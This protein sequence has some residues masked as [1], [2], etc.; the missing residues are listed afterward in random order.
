[1]R[2]EC[3]SPCDHRQTLGPRSTAAPGS[4]Q[5]VSRVIV[6]QKGFEPT[7]V[8][9]P[10]GVP[11]RIIFV[12]ASDATFATEVMIPTL[13]IKRALPLNQPVTVEFTP[14]KAGEVAGCEY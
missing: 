7:R 14:Q 12:R 9:V 13:D 2:S 3:D 6:S 1:M 4:P 5:N 10:S 11:A 8:P